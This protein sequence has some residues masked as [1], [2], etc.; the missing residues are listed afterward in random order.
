MKTNYYYY[1]HKNARIDN[2]N[3]PNN[4]PVISRICRENNTIYIRYTNRNEAEGPFSSIYELEQKSFILSEVKLEKHRKRILKTSNMFEVKDFIKTD[5]SDTFSLDFMDSFSHITMGK[6]SDKKVKGIHFYNPKIIRIL[7]VLEMDSKT[8]VYSARISRLNQQTGKWI[9][10]EEITTF[11]PDEW[12]IDKLFQEYNYAFRNKVKIKG[13]E[14]HSRT[15]EGILVKI[16][17]DNGKIITF[18]PIFD[19]T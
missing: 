17:M 16:V 1:I 19:I 2:R 13:R 9:D 5:C 7:Q 14:Y 10:K 12:T 15:S 3:N 6:I 11:F 18:Y 4:L 8:K